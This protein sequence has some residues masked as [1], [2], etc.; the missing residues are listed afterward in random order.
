MKST[1]KKPQVVFNEQG[2]EILDDTP[3][4]LKPG[5][6]IPQNW[7]S[8]LAQFVKKALNEKAEDQGMESFEEANDFDCPE[9]DDNLELTPYE[10][11]FDHEE[12]FIQDVAEN[13]KK[14]RLEALE[15]AQ[16]EGKKREGSKSASKRKAVAKATEPTPEGEESLDEEKQSAT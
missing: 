10:E 5:Y 7:A 13:I 2:E 16:Q 9:E 3:V 15:K 4:A 1:T 14:R 8:S 6:H 12:N 11:H